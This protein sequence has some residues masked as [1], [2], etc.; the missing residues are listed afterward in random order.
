MV[1]VNHNKMASPR[2]IVLGAGGLLGFEVVKCLS[3]TNTDVK[4]VV[5]VRQARR[6][7]W[8]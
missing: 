7:P 6:S 1:M 8:C 3:V 5:R 4:A 2:I